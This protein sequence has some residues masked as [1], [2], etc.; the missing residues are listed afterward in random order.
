M[1]TDLLFADMA[2]PL[3]SYPAGIDGIAFYGGGDTPHVWTLQ[4]IIACP[5][6]YRLPIFTR[7][8]PTSASATADAA[9]MATYLHS[10][11]AP[12]GTL[13]ALDSETSVDAAYVKSYVTTLNSLGW[14]VIDYG[15]ASSVFG[16]DNPDGYYWA[17]DW[18]NQEHLVS[19]SQMTQYV[20]FSSY[21][22]SEAVSSLPF[23]DTQPDI[24][25]AP[26]TPT[27]TDE[28]NCMQ[29]K[30][31]TG[32][33]DAIRFPV[34][35]SYLFLLADVGQAGGKATEVR[36]ALHSGSSATEADWDVKMVTLTTAAP[37]VTMALP[38]DTYDGASFVR[39]D[40]G[41]VVAVSWR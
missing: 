5:Y 39:Q 1:A 4:E 31:G 16:N 11:G 18:T 13:T 7:S 30:T 22:E 28:E 26:S 27:V 36:V 24:T 6:R 15:S 12:A 14:K 21:D 41:P 10:I 37:G 2:Y 3:S 32:A 40:D 23:W 20:S 35:P 17:A 19:G 8:D 29:L 9:A 33:V 34:F 25:P 38:S